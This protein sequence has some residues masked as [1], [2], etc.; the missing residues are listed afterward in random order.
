MPRKISIAAVQMDANPAL[1]TERLVR[2]DRLV[3]QA[4]QAGAQLVVLP[5]LFNTGYGYDEV[6]YSLVELPDGPTA[7]WMK[8]SAARLN[9]HLGG[10][11]M[12]WDQG[13]VYNALLLFAPDGRIWRYDKSYPWAWERSY[14]RNGSRAVVAETDL[15]DL[16]LMIC[17]DVAHLDLWKRYAGRVDMIVISSCPPDVSNPTFHF[18]SG[19]QLTFEEMGR[20]M[21]ALKGVGGLT[22]G[23]VINQQAAWLGVPAVNTVGS[24]QIQTYL[25]NGLA[26]LIAFLPAAPK[27]LKYLPQA[28][29]VQ[30][31]CQL[32][33]GC[34]VVGANGRV[35][36]ELTQ[37][38]GE[39]FT[40]A[41]VRLADDRP[42][43]GRS[44]PAS[45]VPWIAYLIS[46]VLLPLLSIP[47]YRKGIRRARREG[48]GRD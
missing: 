16:G 22:F 25:P 40:V 39:A 35:L 48:A 43:P 17:W 2:A 31:S 41:E 33:P 6:N 45:P 4:A 29:Q 37:A 14:F 27:L 11:L 46:D 38:Q 3:T 1:T 24:G 8:E 34:K 28:S 12:L 21:A 44:Q 7:T 15:G 20:G 26:T 18:L 9:V 10:S 23:D 42:S 32:V 19:D 13:Q 47:V 30:M 36:T 5:E